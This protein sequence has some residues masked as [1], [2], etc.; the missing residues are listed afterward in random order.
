MSNLSVALDALL[1]ERAQC[2]HEINDVTFQLERLNKRHTDLAAAI[3]KLS[4]LGAI[5]PEER[6]H[7]ERRHLAAVPLMPDKPKRQRSSKPFTTTYDYAEVAA[8]A[9]QAHADHIPIS[10]A[11]A[12]RYQM[13][14]KAAK[15]LLERT[16]A[17]GH[18][19]PVGRTGRP[20]KIHVVT[21]PAEPDSEPDPEPAVV[22]PPPPPPEPDPDALDVGEID[23]G[24]LREMAIDVIA[25]EYLELIRAGKKPIPEL[26]RKYLCDSKAV[27]QVLT[28]A[29]EVGLLPPR[30]Q[31]QLS[32]DE[33][34][35]LL[36]KVP[37]QPGA[38]RR[39]GMT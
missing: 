12:E 9:R 17:H 36:A 22:A 27:S 10:T 30:D 6:V 19:F 21:P 18:D 20:R 38:H 39:G 14:V 11:V 3:D 34:A 33:R 15:S 7:A 28:E 1:A 31:P 13:T 32:D 35:A 24:S 26:T 8:I 4:D 25:A 16:R 23:F 37:N 29:R 2:E 5:S